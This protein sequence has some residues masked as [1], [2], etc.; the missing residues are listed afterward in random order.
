MIDPC[1][2]IAHTLYLMFLASSCQDQR[3]STDGAAPTHGAPPAQLVCYPHIPGQIL[4][5]GGVS[6]YEDSMLCIASSCM[7]MMIEERVTLVIRCSSKTHYLITSASCDSY[8]LP[9][10]ISIAHIC[11]REKGKIWWYGSF[12]INH[13]HLVL[14]FNIQKTHLNVIR[15][16]KYCSFC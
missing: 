1:A 10:K 2:C 6:L 16:S 12:L 14:T 8:M 7:S 9:G 4:V 5:T 3:V 11:V 15:E 13:G